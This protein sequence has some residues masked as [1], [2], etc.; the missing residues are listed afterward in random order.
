M[1]VNTSPIIGVF[2]NRDM[3]ER[4]IDALHNAGFTNDQLSYSGNSAGGGFLAGLKS[5]F[6]GNDED[7][8]HVGNDLVNIGVPQ[9]QAS[10]YANEHAAG[11]PVVAVRA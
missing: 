2:D 9:D 11:H 5:L 4:A 8:S 7:S 10:F 6:T 1:A 3:A